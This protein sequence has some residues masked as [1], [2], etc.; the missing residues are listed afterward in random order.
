MMQS[1]YVMTMPG[2]ETL[3]FGEVRAAIPD[4]A[5]VKFSRGIAL[6]RT[7]AAPDELLALRTAEDVFALLTHIPR[8]ERGAE[9]LRAFQSAALRVDIAKQLSLWHRVHHQ[10][11]RTWRVVSQMTGT[12]SF[13]RVD[14]G[15]A[16]GEAL[17]KAL[18]RGMKQVEDDAD[19]EFW[20]WIGG[21]EALIGLRLSDATMRHRTYKREHLPASLRPTIAA[22]M[23][24]L[25]RPTA[26]DIVLDPLCGA[27]TIIIE[28]ALLGPSDRLIGGDIRDES[29]ALARRNARAADVMAT[30]RVWDARALPLDGAA[31]TRVITNLPFG[32]QIGSREENIK[33]YAALAGEFKRVVAP[34]GLLVAL[35]SEDQLWETTLHEHG[36]RLSKKVVFVVLGQPASIFVA[37]RA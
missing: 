32:K 31:V 11:P 15:K 28:R 1:Y 16:V 4:A 37:E 6:F 7:A 3:A 2:L 25:A 33:L 35:T 19:L 36:W 10:F 13:R 22:T 29:V 14:A 26:N 20:L 12:H 24:W 30:W 18:P 17:K 27:G 21:N 8:L 5:L 34:G 23:S 9:A